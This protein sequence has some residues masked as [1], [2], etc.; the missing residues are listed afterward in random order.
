M[1]NELYI[2]NYRNLK[3]LNIPSLNRV[4]LITGKNNT[5][6]SSLLEAIAIYT[7][8]GDIDVI[9]QFL[10][11]RGE[12]YK[13]AN[14]NISDNTQTNIKSLSSLFYN[15]VAGFDIKDYI[16]IAANVSGDLYEVLSSQNVVLKFIKY[17]DEINKDEEGNIIKRRRTI[18]NSN[19]EKED[20][21][22]GFK[23]NSFKN[24]H[25]IPL[26]KIRLSKHF[27]AESNNNMQMVKTRNIDKQANSYLFD[28]IAL[29]EKEKY[30][31]KALQIIEPATE[32]IAFVEESLRSRKAV[33]KLSNSNAILPLQSMGDGI[34][35]ILSIILSLV[36][37]ENGYLL[38][39]EFENGLH[40]SVQE[41]LWK[42]IF[43]ISKELNIQVFA[44]THSNDSISTFQNVLNNQEH[45]GCGQLIRL[46][47]VNNK[48]V[49]TE[50][51]AEELKIATNQNIEIR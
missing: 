13:S 26:E 49:V 6:K 31:I 38:I 44:T 3:E 48:I 25:F 21:K 2:N 7:S 29:T 27:K 22:I 9:N 41:K 37:S 34:N 12:N 50:F 45:I 32:R 10:E 47:N 43:S 18:A 28:K 30:V 33:I 17:A 46:D 36:N 20:Y 40:Y 1:I 16:T 51:D 5:G 14:D 23:I 15:R 35:R 19:A 8:N 11:D 4:N 24:K 39:D 42:I